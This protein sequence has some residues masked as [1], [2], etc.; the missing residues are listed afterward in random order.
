[1]VGQRCQTS[2]KEP[3]WVFSFSAAENLCLWFLL[4]FLINESLTQL[5]G[6][7]PEATFLY[8][9]LSPCF[10]ITCEMRLTEE[11]GLFHLGYI[12]PVSILVQ[13]AINDARDYE[14][15]MVVPLPIGILRGFSR[16][17]C[18]T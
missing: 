4:L 12:L 5:Q 17:S 9:H 10:D 13:R 6:K 11:M 14:G 18:V 2:V 1:M 15:V 8:Q 16:S 3:Y 7:P